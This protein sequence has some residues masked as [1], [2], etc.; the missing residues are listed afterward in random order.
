[1][2]VVLFVALGEIR[3]RQDQTE[4]K[5]LHRV[6]RAPGL[7]QILKILVEILSGSLNPAVERTDADGQNQSQRHSPNRDC[8]SLQHLLIRRRRGRRG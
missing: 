8:L 3:I 7:I 5:A 4:N 6:E 2:R 1:M